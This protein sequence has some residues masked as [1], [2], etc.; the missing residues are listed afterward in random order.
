MKI[1]NCENVSTSCK[2]SSVSA[3]PAWSIYGQVCHAPP[4][5]PPPLR[6]LFCSKCPNVSF[7]PSQSLVRQN[8]QTILKCGASKKSITTPPRISYSPH[9]ELRQDL[10][11]GDDEYSIL[12]ESDSR[13]RQSNNHS[14]WNYSSGERRALNRQ[15]TKRIERSSFTDQAS[16]SWNLLLIF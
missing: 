3:S 13:S 6:L 4:R 12:D 2:N 5:H 16:S 11:S 1:I 15:I 9:L 8:H 14:V 7:N 10:N